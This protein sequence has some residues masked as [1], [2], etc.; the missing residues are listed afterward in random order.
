[1]GIGACV[2]LL[3]VGA[4]LAFATDWYVAGIDI[5][6]VGVILMVA[7]AIGLVVT[8]QVFRP[9]SR[10]AAPPPAPPPYQPQGHYPPQHQP[11]PPQGQPSQYPPYRGDG[12]R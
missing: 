12:Y 3:A 11:Y 6:A 7:G 5:D 4:V 9:R 8:L 1:M 2:T 10:Q